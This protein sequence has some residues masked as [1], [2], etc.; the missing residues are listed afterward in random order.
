[1]GHTKLTDIL[2]YLSHQYQGEEC[3]IL[4]TDCIW[5]N[6]KGILACRLIH[7]ASC[8]GEE[9]DLR[10]R[11]LAETEV[12]ILFQAYWRERTVFTFDYMKYSGQLMCTSRKNRR[13]LSGSS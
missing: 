10:L 3:R 1:M 4:E 6:L 12:S 9:A 7:T 11:I 5:D 13:I 8:L 2:H